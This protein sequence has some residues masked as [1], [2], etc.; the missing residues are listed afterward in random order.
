MASIT[1]GTF[2]SGYIYGADQ[3]MPWL[4]LSAT[5]AVVGLMIVAFVKEPGEVEA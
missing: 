4:V 3:S 1:L 2:L 5:V